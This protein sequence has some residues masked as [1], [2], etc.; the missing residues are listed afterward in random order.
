MLVKDV[1]VPTTVSLEPHS[2]I[3]EAISIFRD[4]RHSAI[5]IVDSNNRLIGMFTRSNLF[6]CLL[7]GINIDTELSGH[8]ITDIIYFR[9]DKRFNNFSE[10]NQWLRK[11]HISQTPVVDLQG[12]PIG[13]F[14]DDIIV[15][16]LLDHI[17]KYYRDKLKEDPPKM[18]YANKD[19]HEKLYKI[20]GTKYDI[21]SI[22]GESSEME[23][24]KRLALMAA[25]TASTI[26]ITGGCGTGKELFAQAI[27]NASSR[28]Y[29]PFIN[30]N[31]AAIPTELA[32]SEL[33]GYEGGAFTGASKHGK[34]GKFE[35]ADKSTIFLDEIGDMPLPL[36]SKLL[37]IIQEKEVMRV[38]G[39][40]PKK[41][42]IRIIAA[43]NQDLQ[44]LYHEGK[45]RQD[46]YYRLKVISL[47]IPPLS[48]HS[49]DI[50][51]LVDYFI[52]IHSKANNK[53]IKGIS[54]DA[55]HYLLS[56]DWPGNI[57]ELGNVIER[58]ILFCKDKT[59]RL[60][61]L[62]VTN[63]NGIAESGADGFSLSDIE[64]DTILKAL[65]ATNGNKSKTAKILGISRSALYEK[66]KLL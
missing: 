32:E 27:H 61:D 30:I 14:T 3:R 9:E 33:F 36:Q 2:K 65:Q 39:L 25:Q 37:R 16:Y 35:L 24:L 40:H 49:E 19:S 28:W 55:M 8:F 4:T 56:Y 58:A 6:D 45:F 5:P 11:I 41:I 60:E 31:C 23:K 10:L 50:P 51:N 34:P 57:R 63:N 66:L 22:I 48:A 17:E 18:K 46:L 15:C 53:H 20:N 54:K 7:N 42:D 29:Q 13:F 26:L 62:G 43:T 52:E 38:G 64:K 44:K 21:D 1:M 59:I 12:S 47:N